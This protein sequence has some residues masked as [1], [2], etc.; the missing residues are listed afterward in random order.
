VHRRTDRGVRKSG[1]GRRTRTEIERGVRWQRVETVVETIKVL[2]LV[3]LEEERGWCVP[4]GGKR[5]QC[6]RK[7]V[8][9]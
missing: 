1:A 9:V 7:S 8:R 3:E 6:M 4:A 5:Q 2:L